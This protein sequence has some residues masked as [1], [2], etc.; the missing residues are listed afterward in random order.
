[1]RCVLCIHNGATP[2]TV[3]FACAFSAFCAII[4]SNIVY[5][6]YICFISYECVWLINRVLIERFSLPVIIFSSAHAAQTAAQLITM[7]GTVVYI[8]HSNENIIII[9]RCEFFG[10]SCRVSARF[11]GSQVHELHI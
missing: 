11:T 10:F 9:K 5:V 1:M 8:Y 4:C 3:K 7:I 2:L 6:M